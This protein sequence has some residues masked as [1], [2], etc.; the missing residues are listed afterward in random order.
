MKI[1]KGLMPIEYP[2]QARIERG[3]LVISI[4]LNTLAN[5]VWRS[6]RLE[7]A[8]CNYR[9]TDANQFAGEVISAMWVEEEDGSSP[10]TNFLDDMAKAAIE[11]GSI[12][13]EPM[14]FDEKV[15]MYMR[16]RGAK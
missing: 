8:D 3:Q 9:V 5:A 6:P 1:P 15:A 13:V 4:G 14:T 2:L 7:Q 10:L 16:E 12:A 11:D